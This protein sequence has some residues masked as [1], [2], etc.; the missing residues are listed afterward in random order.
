MWMMR[1]R[2]VR[3]NMKMRD[4]A[5]YAVEGIYYAELG[6]GVGESAELIVIRPTK[7]T[8]CVDARA[9]DKAIIPIC[10][11]LRPG[12]LNK[13]YRRKLYRKVRAV[14]IHPVPNG[15]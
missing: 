10:R 8:F 3:P 5:Y 1:Y 2:D 12:K 15:H 7:E 6:S 4:A 9:V 11:K 13:R 14:T